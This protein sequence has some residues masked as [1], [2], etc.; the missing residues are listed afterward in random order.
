MGRPRGSQNKAT[1]S[2]KAKAA[3]VAT[4]DVV[5]TSP[6][7]L[8]PS[9]SQQIAA[10]NDAA[11]I[12]PEAS[13]QDIPVIVSKKG[14]EYSLSEHETL[15]NML[16]ECNADGMDAD[17]GF[18]PEVWS[19]IA[20]ALPGRD[21]ASVASA[22]QR[23]SM[24]NFRHSSELTHSQLK[25][26]WSAIEDMRKAASGVPFDEITG[27]F[28]LTEE[29]WAGYLQT[30]PDVSKYKYVGFP[31]Y[32][33]ICSL[34]DGKLAN[35][36]HVVLPGKRKDTETLA[37]TSP[38]K[39]KHQKK[40]EVQK[41]NQTMDELNALK[42]LVEDVKSAGQPV[43]RTSPTLDPLEANTPQRRMLAMKELVL[44]RKAGL[45]G[46]HMKAA[47]ASFKREPA[48]ID[49][50]LGCEDSESRRIFIEDLIGD[51]SD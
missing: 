29:E 1:V 47:I 11:S 39:R 41:D 26:G 8:P 5:N 42:A 3:S 13:Q 24:S 4:A 32:K 2:K 49:F 30:H 21:R 7:D 27:L 15:V 22:W 36:D 43:K 40:V 20:N 9:L 19:K 6:Q 44:L 25:R 16:V 37:G 17:N 31:H 23:V 38:I 45:S 46:D 51:D 18:K 10:R 33:A 28:D 12:T 48:D 35:G 14:E 34:V 50:F